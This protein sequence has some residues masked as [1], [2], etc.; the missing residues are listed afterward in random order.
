MKNIGT[1]ALTKPIEGVP[2]ENQ[3]GH[4]PRNKGSLG[5]EQMSGR[6]NSR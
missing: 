2:R 1:E 3:K 5:I 6:D 4:L